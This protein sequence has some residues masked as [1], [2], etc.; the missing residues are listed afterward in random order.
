MNNK[1]IGV[2]LLIIGIALVI[3]FGF[4]IQSLNQDIES[5]GCF[6]DP[7]CTQIETSLTFVHFAFGIF[8]FLFALGFYLIFFTTGEN[9]IVQRLEAD[10]K[11]NLDE[12][13][14]FILLKGLNSFEKEILNKVR[15]EPGI[16]QSSLRLKVNMSKAKLSQVLIDLENKDLIK[17]QKEGKTLKIFSTLE[18]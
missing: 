14:F 8:G 11:K 4:V 1:K 6:Q 3:I 12:E 2:I 9:A 18:F 17:R 15:S 13:K 7:S 10:T 16:T 5:L